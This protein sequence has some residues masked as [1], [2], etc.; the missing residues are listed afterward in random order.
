[1]SWVEV[2]V[3]RFCWASRHPDRAPLQVTPARWEPC[4][5]CERSTAD[6]IFERVWVD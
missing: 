2:A 1:M 5:L 6:G 4:A 3:C